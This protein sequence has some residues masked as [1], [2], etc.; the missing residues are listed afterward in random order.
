MR[1]EIEIWENERYQ[2]IGNA[3][4]SAG[5]L[6]T[7]RNKYSLMD[8]SISWKALNEVESA[9]MSAGWQWI[10]D[11][12]V[13]P[14]TSA[15]SEVGSNDIDK[16][17]VWIYGAD[18]S[19]KVSEFSPTK[20]RTSFVRCRKMCREQIYQPM[21]LVKDRSYFTCNYC[22]LEKLE[23]LSLLFLTMLSQLSLSKHPRDINILKINNLKTMLHDALELNNKKIVIDELEK[24]LEVFAKNSR[25]LWSMASSLIANNDADTLSKR[26]ADLA[27]H[28]TYDER[29]LLA[30]LVIKIHDTQN[31]YHCNVEGCNK[32]VLHSSLTCLRTYLLVHRTHASSPRKLVGM[33]HVGLFT[34]KDFLRIMIKFVLKKPLIV[35]A[36]VV[37]RSSAAP[38]L[39][40]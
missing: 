31:V 9:M 29:N 18:F 10:N 8:G 37:L 7:D 3:F 40:T 4:S 27:A 33:N 25:D 6:P 26:T 16:D 21:L 12:V 28:F 39:S 14:S 32:V 36:L 17:D 34:A 1:R 35:T 13:L 38:W 19:V 30:S 20:L 5:L 2:P 15:L 11:W 24:H 22:D 23:S